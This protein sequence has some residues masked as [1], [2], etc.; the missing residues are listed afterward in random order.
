MYAVTDEGVLIRFSGNGTG[1]GSH[2]SVQMTC[3]V[4]EILITDP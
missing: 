3:G 4:G 2:V 1:C